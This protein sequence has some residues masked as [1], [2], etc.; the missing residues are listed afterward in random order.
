[1]TVTTYDSYHYDLACGVFDFRT[2]VIKLALTSSSYTPNRATHDKF[3][4]I[5]NEIAAGGGYTSGGWTLASQTLTKDTTNHRAVFD[6]ADINEDPSTISNARYGILYKST[7]TPSTSPLIACIDFATDQSS[8][9][10]PFKVT[11]PTD[12]IDLFKQG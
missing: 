6:A 2:D 5:T 10:G 12:G 8:S 1:M 7:G 9:A 11:W 3:D 4:D